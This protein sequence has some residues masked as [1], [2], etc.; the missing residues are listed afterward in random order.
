VPGAGATVP[1]VSE[2]RRGHLTLLSRAPDFRLLFVATAG[3]AVGTYL[4]ATVL[5]LRMYHLTHSGRWVAG[6]LIADFLP[7][8]VIGL[9]LGPLID[10]LRRKR[11]MV[12]SDLVRSAVFC[13]LPFVDRPGA[14]IG[15]AAISGVA[16]GFFRPAVYAGLPNLVEGDDDLTEANSLL[17]AAENVSWMVG[18]IVAGVVYTAFGVTPAFLLNA[19]TFLLS[20]LLVSRIP[21]NRLQSDA[22]LTRGHWRDVADGIG[23]VLRTPQLRTVLIVWNVVIAGNA[24]LNVGEIFLA[25]KSLHGGNVGY[26]LLVGATGAGLVLGSLAS[27]FVMG[28]I[29]LR[30]LYPAAILIM[31]VGA[32]AAS[33]A[34]S[35]WVAAPLAAFMTVGNAI[36]IVCNQL[37]VQRGAEDAMRG[38][39]IAVLMSSTYITLAIGMGITGTLA[40]EY[41]GRALWAGAGALY[42]FASVVAGILVAAL[43]RSADSPASHEVIEVEPP[44][45]AETEGPAIAVAY[46]SAQLDARLVSPTGQSPFERIRSLLDEVDQTRQAEAERTR[47][48]GR[49]GTPGHA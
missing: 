43:P 39:A 35:V 46:A 48:A 34:P 42:L 10:R 22:P 11:L 33:R 26:A 13:L 9:G 14:I 29:G 23:L 36:A 49:A 47:A 40:N 37:L 18:P 20:A 21:G 4:A 25:Q 5:T 1:R 45:P 38:R 3:S 15:L 8:V 6:L 27:P 17:G 41:G 2:P 28:Q 24:A 19:A 44:D 31:A 7:I 30:R 12:V 32:V 16:T